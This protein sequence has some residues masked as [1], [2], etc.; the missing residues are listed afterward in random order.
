MTALNV[1]GENRIL[2][3]LP[4]ADKKRLTARMEEVDLDTRTILYFP[5][6][7]IE[8][9]YFPLT[10]V[11]S[12]VADLDK[13]GGVEIGTVGNEG[14]LGVPLLHRADRGRF[15]AFAQVAGKALRMEVSVFISELDWDGALHRRANL[16]AQGWLN[17]VAQTGACNA[18]H[19]PKQRMCRW[20]LQTRDRVG[21]DEFLLTKEFLGQMV[22]VDRPGIGVLAG[23]LQRAGLLTYEREVVTIT[24]GAGM[25]RASCECYEAVKQ[26]YIRLLC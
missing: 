22:G 24:N 19:D 15:H 5:D 12:V 9:V 21:A 20:L 26:E 1:A 13:H 11:L 2:T 10:G 3:G 16:Y 18:R 14:M 23:T 25:E 4:P 17:Q 7:R 8:H 6:Q